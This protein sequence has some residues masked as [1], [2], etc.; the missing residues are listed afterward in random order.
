MI[1]HLLQ[2]LQPRSA[3]RLGKLGCSA[4]KYGASYGL[5]FDKRHE[6]DPHGKAQAWSGCQV[7]AGRKQVW[8]GTP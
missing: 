7:A 2:K 8:I 3:P 4:G 6:Y 1:E 5:A